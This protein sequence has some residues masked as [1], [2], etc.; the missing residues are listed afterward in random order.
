MLITLCRSI[1]PCQPAFA[2][3]KDFPAIE[4]SEQ[5]LM[6]SMC[7]IKRS[8]ESRVLFWRGVIKM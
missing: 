2:A 5:R 6:T 4:E 7:I 1:Y 8:E 3:S